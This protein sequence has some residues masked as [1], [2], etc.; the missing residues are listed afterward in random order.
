MGGAS[1]R[2]LKKKCS[3]G[4]GLVCLVTGASAGIGL[5]TA[6]KLVASGATVLLHARTQTKAEA[7]SKEVEGPG[8]VIPVVGDLSCLSEVL[9]LAE[10]VKESC[11]SWICS[12]AM[13][14]FSAPVS[15]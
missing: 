12:S 14:E 4:E 11:S 5:H 2:Q 7:A 10:Q 6:A 9:Q 8:K 1:S 13:Q 15:S 3:M